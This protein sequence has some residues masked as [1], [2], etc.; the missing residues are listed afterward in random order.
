MTCTVQLRKHSVSPTG[1]DITTWVLSYWRPIHG[2]VLTHRDLSRNG[3]SSRALPSKKV[4]SQ[5]WNNPARPIHWGANKAGMQADYQL[6]GW[7]LWAA[8][9][10]WT[11]AEKTS[12]LYA[13]ALNKLG[14]H[15][16]VANRL[17]EPHQWMVI[18][19]TTTKLGNLFELR[20]HK[21]AQPEFQELAHTMRLMYEASVPKKL[22]YGEWHLPFCTDEEMATLDLDTLLKIDT[23]RCARVSML[24]HDGTSS[25]TAAD[26]KLYER[27]V[28]SKPI[29]ASPTEHQATPDIK[30]RKFPDYVFASLH[31][32]FSGWVQHRKILE[33]KH[34]VKWVTSALKDHP[35]TV[36]P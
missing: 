22:N 12:C 13:W 17:L 1:E 36:T 28:G 24:N 19:M 2:E 32:N 9:K 4:I 26:I 3:A 34:S 15:K 33:K 30:M 21:D 7:R 11:L 8:K 25:T 20:D 27:L 35:N 16:Q 5:V 18:V 14:L 23:A 10:V 29:H 6:T 31:G